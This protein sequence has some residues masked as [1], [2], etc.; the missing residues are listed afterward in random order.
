MKG[1][2][3]RRELEHEDRAWLAW[4]AGLLGKL[5]SPPRSPA[6]LLPRKRARTR[7]EMIS[8][9]RGWHYAVKRLQ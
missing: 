9:V 3:R 2:H 7:E 1:A 5:K 6:D 4:H 8:A